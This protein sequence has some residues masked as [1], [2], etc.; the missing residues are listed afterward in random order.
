MR[1]GML[2]IVLTIAVFV[3]PDLVLGGYRAYKLKIT[4]ST[5]G[6]SRTVVSI[7][8]S[9]QYPTYH[10][11]QA[12]ETIQPVDSWM[13]HGNMSHFHPICSKPAGAS[14]APL[15]KTGNPL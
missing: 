7:L 2:V 4:N 5:S 12:S 13:C 8:D 9:R 6:E 14:I 11:L 10:P 15:Q 3:F 1:I